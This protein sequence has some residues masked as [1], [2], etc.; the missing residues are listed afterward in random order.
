MPVR[1]RLE[2]DPTTYLSSGATTAWRAGRIVNSSGSP[3]VRQCTAS[4]EQ[5]DGFFIFDG[6]DGD[7]VTLVPNGYLKAETG[8]AFNPGDLLMTDTSGR[9]VVYAA[10]TGKSYCGE[11]EEASAGAGAFVIVKRPTSA[12]AAA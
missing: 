8:G 1:G 3:V 10:A 9:V 4:G 5:V 2:K 12:S 6:V 7:Y 11:A